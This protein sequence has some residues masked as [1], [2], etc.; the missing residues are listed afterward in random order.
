V[1][2]IDDDEDT[3]ALYT[4]ALGEAGAEIRTGADPA[5]AMRSVSEW[6][7]AVIVSDWVMPGVDPAS[8]LR[9]VRAVHPTKRIP[10]IA[11]TGKSSP[12][13]RK[14]ALAAGFQEHAAKPLIPDALIAIVSRC[15]SA[16]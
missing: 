15:A 11:V 9:D 14:A 12:S 6:P 16:G 10:A 5:E 3:L 13:D 4:F 7:P 1:L 8:L 2:L